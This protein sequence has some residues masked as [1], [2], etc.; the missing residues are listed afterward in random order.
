MKCLRDLYII[1]AGGFGRETAWLV[2]RINEVEHTWNLKGFIDDNE[3][4]QREIFGGYSILGGVEYLKELKSDAWVVIAVGNAEMRKRCARRLASFEHLASATL[5]DPGVELSDSVSVGEGSIIC[6][7]T[8]ITVDVRIGSYNIINLDCTVGHSAE[9]SDFVTLYPSVNVSGNV[10]IGDGTEVGT[11]T[12][13]IQGITVGERTVVGAGAVVIKDIES[14]VTV[15]GNP[16]KVIKRHLS[17]HFGG[18]ITSV[19]IS[20]HKFSFGLR[21]MDVAVA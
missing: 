13:I 8:I 12:Q 6:A 9:F 1:G 2:E 4:L 20:V 3:E 11:G 10:K 21:E 14:D 17:Q 5:I 7:G 18:G 19:E 15:V 16:A